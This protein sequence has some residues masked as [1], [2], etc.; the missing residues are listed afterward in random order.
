[1]LGESP[2]EFLRRMEA[3][4]RDG[5][6]SASGSDADIVRRTITILVDCARLV[7]F[8]QRLKEIVQNENH[9]LFNG[10]YSTLSPEM[11]KHMGLM[12]QAQVGALLHVIRIIKKT[13]E[14]TAAAT[15]KIN[16]ETKR[17]AV[18]ESMR[19]IGLSDEDNGQ[20]GV[21]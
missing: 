17:N 16:E 19:R 3:V 2:E 8:L 7:P 4:A 20:N 9:P 6:L 11:K 13:T 14:Q 1:M 18:D 10:P 12:R 21:L 15:P 5:I